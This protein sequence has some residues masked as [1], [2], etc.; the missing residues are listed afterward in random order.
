MKINSNRARTIA[1]TEMHSAYSEGRHI[2]AVETEP[3][4]KQWI[5]SR[6]PDVRDA[7]QH[8]DGEKVPFNEPYSNGLMYPLDPEGLPKQVINC[9]CVEVYYYED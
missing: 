9:R 3:S 4:H 8:L 6:N 5:S 2:A 1:R 7:H